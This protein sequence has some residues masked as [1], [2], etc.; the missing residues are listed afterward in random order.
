MYVLRFISM[1]TLIFLSIVLVGTESR[2]TSHLVP[3]EN[4]TLAVML[5]AAHARSEPVFLF[6]ARD[7]NLLHESAANLTAEHHCYFRDGFSERGQKQMTEISGK[8]C[9][10][11]SDLSVLAKE[12]FAESKRAIAVDETNYA[13]LLRAAS[14]A[15]ATETALLPVSD[16]TGLEAYG[17]NLPAVET[18]Y[19]TPGA[20]I[21]K[22][23]TAQADWKTQ[24]L[25]TTTQLQN[26]LIR[27]LGRE[28]ITAVIVANPRDRE[29]MFS[30]SSLSLLAPLESGLHKAPLILT[31]SRQAEKVEAQVL[32]VL[33]EQ[34]L[35]PEHI[36]LVGDELAL[37][38]HR[39]KDPVLE[40]GGPEARGG[41]TEIRVELFSEV[42]RKRPQEF[43]VG[44]IVSEGAAQGSVLLARQIHGRT[45]T[46]R[47][48]VTFLT[49]ADSVFALGETISRTTIAELRNVGIPVD[50]YY[51]DAVTSERIQR[52]LTHSDILVWEGH[53]RDLTLEEQ[54]GISAKMAPV[55]VV[56]Q[57]CYTLDRSDPFILIE[58]GTQALVATTAAVYSA[59]GSAFA[60]ALFDTLLHD[61]ADIG[62]AVRYARNYLLGLA[63]LQEHRGHTEWQKTYRAALSF[64]LWGDPTIADLP[65]SVSEAS[66][67]AVK[68]S[69]SG[70]RLKLRIPISRLPAVSV[71]HYRVRPVSRSM[72][73]G[74][75]L[76]EEG[77]ELRRLKQ[78]Y[79][80]SMKID[81]GNRHVC[82][83]GPGWDV[84]SDY[85]PRTGH[86]NVI[87]RADWDV[88]EGPANRG[89]FSF[90]LV[91]NAD[92]CSVAEGG[93][94]D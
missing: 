88:V 70:D 30:P 10:K 40:A 79:F 50:A 64:A 73:G 85:A 69:H 45:R 37:R 20:K 23:G 94:S 5:M 52:S 49:N 74:L 2:A 26:E 58:K 15:A 29:G 92:D 87:A 21:S 17:T 78:L 19:L 59:P 66:V 72:L 67:A 65:F 25:A 90:P 36:I 56:L 8:P 62:S 42:H 7:R 13:W 35:D 63:K 53:P 43:A 41:G 60:R 51:R 27:T 28:S 34:Q 71:D 39:V 11:I 12:L 76:R 9:R 54:G 22:Q 83:P 6:D 32:K 84:I 68:W 75:V 38:S 24:N 77:S 18:L 47:R 80:G 31:T 89:E 14:F 81:S 4:P 82:P 86:L 55:F 48:P 46:R 3:I 93:S 91:A 33:D 1:R 44:R 57:G 61:S 16:K